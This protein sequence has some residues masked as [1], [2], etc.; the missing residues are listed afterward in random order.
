M[1]RIRR[2]SHATVVAYLALF[3]ALGGTAMAS[4]IITNNSQVDRGT[5]S[6]HR[7]P[8]GKH[9]NIIRGSVSGKDILES[10]LGE[11]PR[12]KIGGIG[13]WTGN[14]PGTNT[15]NPDSLTY[16]SCVATTVNLPRSAHV[17]VTGEV[18]AIAYGTAYATGRC[19]IGTTS[20]PLLD[21]DTIASVADPETDNAALVGITGVLP[22]GTH[23][24][25]V[26]CNQTSGNVEYVGPG[27][28][29]VAISPE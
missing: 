17:L 21:T 24:F 10:T 25:G 13:R 16:V 4:V 14:A 12:A 6:G 15:C 11:V 5:I 23:S 8:S 19:R 9:P 27:V 7:P 20:G 18:Q 3:V 26:D 2:P 29:A 28:A 22:A 1:R